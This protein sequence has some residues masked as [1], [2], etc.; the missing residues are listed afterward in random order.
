[1]NSFSQANDLE[2]MPLKKLSDCLLK[3]TRFE[4]KMLFFV[5]LD[6]F[7]SEGFLQPDP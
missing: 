2:W 3:V 5:N 6:M 4:P 7:L 1:M